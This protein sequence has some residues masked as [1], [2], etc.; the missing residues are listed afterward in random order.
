[1]F[2]LSVIES[3][4]SVLAFLFLLLTFLLMKFGFASNSDRFITIM[5]MATTVTMKMTM[6]MM[7]MLQQ[8]KYITRVKS[9]NNGMR[10]MSC[11]I[12]IYPTRNY[13]DLQSRK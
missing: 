7:V 10:S 6:T 11:Y 9:W 8:N 3:Y 1:M 2:M 5:M 4:P 12:L 13:W